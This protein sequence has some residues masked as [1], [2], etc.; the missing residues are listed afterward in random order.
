MKWKKSQVVSE[1]AEKEEVSLPPL[2]SG[3]EGL[4]FLLWAHFELVDESVVP[5]PF[6]SKRQAREGK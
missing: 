3:F 1:S 2:W 4:R 5:G 6:S